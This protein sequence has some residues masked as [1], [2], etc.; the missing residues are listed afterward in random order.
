[1]NLTKLLLQDLVVNLDDI[2]KLE[3]SNVFDMKPMLTRPLNPQSNPGLV[4]EMSFEMNLDQTV[5][6]RD[7]YTILDVLS[8]MGGF[9]RVLFS[10]FSIIAAILNMSNFDSYLASKLYKLNDNNKHL[11]QDQNQ[12]HKPSKS[13][14]FQHKETSSLKEFIGK[15]LPRK[16]LCKAC[17]KNKRQKDIKMAVDSLEKEIDIVEMIR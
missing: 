6:T 3:D 2:T 7:G 16:M 8:D 14:Y 9:Q 17:R 15:I 1:M 10:F 5:I 4:M 13:I 12:S 11:G